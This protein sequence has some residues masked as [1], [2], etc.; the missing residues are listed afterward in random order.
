MGN[1]SAVLTHLDDLGRHLRLPVLMKAPASA[2]G[3]HAIFPLYPTSGLWFRSRVPELCFDVPLFFPVTQE[4]RL[5]RMD[6][7]SLSYSFLANY[8]FFSL[9]VS[10]HMDTYRL[11]PLKPNCRLCSMS[12]LIASNVFMFLALKTQDTL[13]VYCTAKLGW[14]TR[15]D[16]VRA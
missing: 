4:L 16:V 15:C 12:C 8:F 13:R 2:L 5:A 6:G 7:S 10:L 1:T 14:V 9:P 11:L 3:T